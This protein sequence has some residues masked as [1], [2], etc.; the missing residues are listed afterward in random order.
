MD[1]PKAQHTAAAINA[2]WTSRH[3][4]KAGF[5]ASAFDPTGERILAPGC[6]RLFFLERFAMIGISHTDKSMKPSLPS[7]RD[8]HRMD[9]FGRATRSLLDS[10]KTAFAPELNENGG[11]NRRKP[12]QGLM[13]GKKQEDLFG[14]AQVVQI[15]WSTS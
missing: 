11:E 10:G 5:A 6:I 2:A 4:S 3:Q 12:R 13:R 9:S 8:E 1:G 7:C 14:G 15:H